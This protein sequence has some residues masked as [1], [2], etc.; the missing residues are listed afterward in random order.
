MPNAVS[1]YFEAD[2]RRDNDAIVALFTDD[3]VVVD[4]GETRRGI[5]DIRAWRDGAASRYDYTT[6]VF[7]IERTGDHAY[8]VV[9]RLTGNFPGGT[10]DLKWRFTLRG[11]RIT[12]LHIAP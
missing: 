12:Y 6:E 2:A 5:D 4:E 8:L 1:G 9:G 11:D 3:A 7:D 10:A